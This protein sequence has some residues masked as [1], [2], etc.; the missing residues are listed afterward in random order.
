ME[1][2]Y[3]GPKQDDS[4]SVNTLGYICRILLNLVSSGLLYAAGLYSVSVFYIPAVFMTITF[5][6]YLIGCL[7]KQPF[8]RSFLTFYVMLGSATAYLT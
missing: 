1:V 8:K 5:G 7:M 2:L 3:L 4:L 6:L